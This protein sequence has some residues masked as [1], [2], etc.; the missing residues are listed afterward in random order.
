MAGNKKYKRRLRNYLINSRF[1][2]KAATIITL[3]LMVGVVL[4]IVVGRQTVLRTY[5]TS[6]INI[7]GPEGFR[8]FLDHLSDRITVMTTVVLMMWIGIVA[9][10]SVIYLHRIAGPIYRFQ[11]V[12]KQ[13]SRGHVPPPFHL[14]EKDFFTD[15][16]ADFN[17]ALSIL[18]Q[19]RLLANGI[20][21]RVDEILDT[22]DL[23]DEIRIRLE[24]A[25]EELKRVWEVDL[26]DE[27]LTGEWE[28]LAPLPLGGPEDSAF[29][30]D[31]VWWPTIAELKKPKDGLKLI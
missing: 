31:V 23:D 4:A 20:A 6:D 1:Q 7:T 14:R 24:A 27:D 19:R 28:N 2:L 5:M 15:V 16:A 13:I 29:A 9:G 25:S 12:L 30:K 21:F 8:S 22:Y 26:D 18:D 3:V 10:I 11:Q 17:R